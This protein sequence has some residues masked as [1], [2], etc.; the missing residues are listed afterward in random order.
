MQDISLYQQ[1]LGLQSPWRVQ[2]V[3]LKIKEQEVEVVVAYDPA[4]TWACPECRQL[5]GIHDHVERRWRHLDS[6]QFKTMVR[7]RVPRVRCAAHGLVTV[8]VPWAEERARFTRLF[9]RL[10]IDVLK[11][12]SVTGS[13]GLLRISWDEAQGILERAVK[14]GL[15][16]KQQQPLRHL[17]IDE[18][19]FRKRHDY[20]TLVV[21]LEGG[22]ES[23]TVEY[24]G[25]GRDEQSLEEFWQGLSE[26]R[27]AGIEAVALDLWQPYQNSVRAHLPGAEEKMVHDRFHLM[28]HMVEAVDKVRKAEHRELRQEGYDL[29][30]GTKY[31][32]LHSRENLPA[33]QRAE[34]A[35]LR[36]ANLKVGRAWSIKE[37]LRQ[38]WNYRYQGAAEKFFGRWHGW[39]MRSRLEPVKKVARMFRRHLKNILTFLHHPITTAAAENVSGNWRSGSVVM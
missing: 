16:R 29:L 21:N 13:C 28:G 36:G 31:W 14:R 24:V 7:A 9:E 25:Q 33:A 39:A 23:P 30:S 18:K 6:C 15:A 19:S 11:E 38:L 5:I 1:L 27:R 35:I 4:T 32:W 10:A 12:C 22:G 34:F 2:S 3:E 26:A 37:T 20:V 17:A 8:R